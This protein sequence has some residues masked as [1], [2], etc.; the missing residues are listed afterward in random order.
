MT[1]A[2]DQLS[3]LFKQQFLILIVTVF[4]DRGALR[5]LF[6]FVHITGYYISLKYP[7]LVKI[8]FQKAISTFDLKTRWLSSTSLDNF[9][10]WLS[11]IIVIVKPVPG[12]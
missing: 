5:S 2:P 3:F 11:E 6:C 4:K 12:S 1:A 8:S 9:I 10:L 7:C